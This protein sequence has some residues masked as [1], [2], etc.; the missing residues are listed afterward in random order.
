MTEEQSIAWIFLSIAVA[1]EVQPA[2]ISGISMI[3]DGINHAVPT[4]KEFQTSISWLIK[5][6]LILK[7]AKKYELSEKGKRE[8]GNVRRKDIGYLKMM[9]KLEQAFKNI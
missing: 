5:K 1:S 7:M 9:E 4:N 3:A 6:G 2:K 8:F